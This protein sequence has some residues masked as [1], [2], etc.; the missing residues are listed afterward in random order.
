ML[1]K[2]QKPLWLIIILSFF[3]S[4]SVYADAP[5]QT[6]QKLTQKELRAQRRL[7]KRQA[8]KLRRRQR[9]IKRVERFLKSRL[10]KWLLKRALRKASNRKK[11]I[12]LTI[13]LVLLLIGGLMYI[14]LLTSTGIIAALILGLNTAIFLLAGFIMVIISFALKGSTPNKNEKITQ[15]KTN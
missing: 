13:G 1:A 14:G 12:V 7:E 9:K 5:N 4:L 10:G 3:M 8:R 11:K 6:R 2:H 15:E